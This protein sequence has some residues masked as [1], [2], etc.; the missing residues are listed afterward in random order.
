MI[1]MIRMTA[2]LLA[3][4]VFI[5]TALVLSN[6]DTA[7]AYT[8]EKSGPN[9]DGTD[10][11]GG[12]LEYYNGTCAIWQ[13][14]DQDNSRRILNVD[15]QGK[16]NYSCPS[17]M[18][19]VGND[20]YTYSP[21]LTSYQPTYDDGSNVPIEVWQQICAQ[22]PSYY[23]SGSHYEASR[24]VCEVDSNC[25][26]SP[27]ETST[28]GCRKIGDGDF[29]PPEDVL[30]DP[31]TP[32]P[33]DPN[34]PNNQS[35]DD[36]KQPAAGVCDS[37]SSSGCN[38]NVTDHCGT[39]RVNLIVCGNENSDSSVVFNEVLRIAVFALTIMIGIASVGGLAWASVQYAKAEDDSGKVSEARG[40][41]RNIIIG[42]LLYVFLVGIVNMLVPGGIIQ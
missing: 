28:G 32:P 38:N 8:C 11:N 42:L 9:R 34:D 16:V 31:T 15:Q 6:P 17:D 33:A 35:P 18:K 19:Q 3:C 24:H 7:W 30:E 23:G 25:F 40:L 36:E 13:Q 29:A 2:A 12:D 4:F 14:G 37:G 5:S 22:G 41:I 26:T 1:A 21:F 39:A 20:C 27:N 10:G